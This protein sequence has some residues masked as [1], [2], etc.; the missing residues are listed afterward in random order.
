MS[1]EEKKETLVYVK[2]KLVPLKELEKEYPEISLSSSSANVRVIET[3][4]KTEKP[5][6][7]SEIAKKT[8]LSEAYTRDVLK[9][10]SRKDYVLEFRLGG[11]TRYFLLTE[12]GLKLSKEIAS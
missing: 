8:G 7:R 4:T 2:G 12:K 6:N 10:L 11:R 1:E 5:L 3:L 9:R